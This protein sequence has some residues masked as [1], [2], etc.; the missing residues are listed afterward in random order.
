MT[1]DAAW[2]DDVFQSVDLVFFGERMHDEGVV[3]RWGRFRRRTKSFRAGWFWSEP[4]PVVELSPVL[5]N[6]WV[7]LHVVVSTLYHELLHHVHGGGGESWH[8]VE[9]KH[10]EQRDPYF[11]LS[12]E[13][14]TE[15]R[16]RLIAARPPKEGA[17]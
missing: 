6:D 1:R 11:A 17:Q 12:D 9:F 8:S 16:A 2:L 5:R 10:A 15:N 4:A 7:P 14:V 13:W 3:V